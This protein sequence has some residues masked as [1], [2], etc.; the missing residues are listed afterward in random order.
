VPESMR[1]WVAANP[2]SWLVG[3]LRDALLQGNLALDWSD[4]LAVAV[5]FALYF[6][7]R[8]VFRRLAPNFEDFI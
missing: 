7:G 1:A 8:W 4:A 3:R 6:A 2:F 5:A